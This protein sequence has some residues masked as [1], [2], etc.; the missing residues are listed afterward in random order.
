MMTTL[1]WDHTVHNV[2][3]LDKAIS[4]FEQNGL[5]AFHGGSHTEWGTYNA[6]SYFGL[7][8]IELMGIE[9]EELAEQADSTHLIVKDA[10]NYLP[11]HE[12]FGR[13]A[14]RTDNIEETAAALQAKGL[15]LSSIMNGKRLNAQG[16]LIEWKMMTIQGDFQ[17]LAYPFIIQ[18]KGTDEERLEQLTQ[19]GVIQPHPVG[20][21]TIQAAVF[22]VPSPVEVAKYWAD[23]FGLSITE[24]SDSSSTLLIGEQKF[25]FKQGTINRLEQL[26]FYTETQ[27]IKGKTMIIG[28]AEYVFI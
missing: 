14:L 26:V 17:G 25:I 6:L 21:I 22:A 20:E 28:E 2:N 27:S 13:V 15:E 9:K 8:Y 23:L 4:T 5:I 10:L 16:Q 12:A 18:W 3:D 24:S 19:S 11:E 1:R 7:T